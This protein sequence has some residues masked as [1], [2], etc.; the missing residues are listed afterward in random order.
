MSAFSLDV[1][2]SCFGEGWLTRWSRLSMP[3]ELNGDGIS[4]SFAAK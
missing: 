3:L 2:L 1:N 4:A